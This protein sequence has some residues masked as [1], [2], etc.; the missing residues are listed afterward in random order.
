MKETLNDSITDVSMEVKVGY[1]SISIF[2]DN[3][4][5]I[6]FQVDQIKKV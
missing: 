4:K 1:Y 5:N 2:K 3:I 6:S